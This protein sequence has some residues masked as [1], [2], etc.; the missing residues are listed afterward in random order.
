MAGEKGVLRCP[1]TVA[2]GED[3]SAQCRR[4]IQVCRRARG[5]GGDYPGEGDGGMQVVVVDGVVN[6]TQ[7]GLPVLIA[8][9]YL[10]GLWFPRNRGGFLML[11]LGRGQC[12]RS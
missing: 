8:G 10:V 11:L 2:V 5:G 6:P 12:F 7:A 9:R 1:V 3:T 4:V